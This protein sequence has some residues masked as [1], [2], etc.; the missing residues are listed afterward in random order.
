MNTRRSFLKTLAALIV[1][2]KAILEIAKAAPAPHTENLDALVRAQE[3]VWAAWEEAPLLFSP[4]CLPG[5]RRPYHSGDI[6][7]MEVAEPVLAG[8]VVMV[9]PDLKV[10]P[11]LRIGSGDKHLG[12]ALQSSDWVGSIVRVRVS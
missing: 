3:R 7:Y 8:Q 1:A 6:V 11:S 4:E 12:R 9:S 5:G 10:R 2:P